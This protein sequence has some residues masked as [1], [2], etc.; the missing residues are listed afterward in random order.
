VPELRQPA[1]PSPVRSEPTATSVASATPVAQAS[2]AAAPP[3]PAPTPTPI[4][5]R[6]DANYLDNPK[7][8]Y[9]PLSRKANEEGKV[10]LKVLVEPNGLP[11]RVEISHSSGFDRLDKS[12]VTAVTRWKFTPAR[13]GSEAVA[14][15]ISVP[16]HFSLND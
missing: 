15:W 11:S 12:A 3:A 4:P 16:I 13:L 9:P 5:A 6:L 2:P 1:K 7:P 10:V 8:V 14:G